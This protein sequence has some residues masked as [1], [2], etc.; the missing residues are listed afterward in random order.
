MNN[1]IRGVYYIL[2]KINN[3]IYIGSSCRIYKRFKE[4]R[5]F[6]NKNKH[7]NKHLQ[8][9][10]NKYNEENFE[11]GI[12][13]IVCDIDD[14]LLDAE[15]AWMDY[16]NS[17]DIQYGYNISAYA[18]GSGGYK[19]SEETKEKIRQWHIGQKASEET[20]NKLSLLR[21]GELNGF[22]G[23][24][25]SEEAKEKIKNSKVGKKPTQKQLDNLEK[26]R[27]ICIDLLKDKEKGENLRKKLSEMRCGEKSSSAKLTEVEVIEILQK[28][29]QGVLMKDLC[30]FY[31]VSIASISRIKNRKRWGYL[32]DKYPELYS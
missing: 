4:H 2:N 25:H 30:E 1:D 24:H 9:A 22:Y 16:F 28:L 27:K 29:K 3:K 11:F 13:E 14:D 20:K 21:K 12:I 10:W 6:L 31:N 26:G 5:Y 19:V 7:I 18:E 23:K 15:Q 8:R 17:Y 32:Y